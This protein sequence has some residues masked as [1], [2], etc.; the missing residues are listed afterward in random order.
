[1]SSESVVSKQKA[2][3]QSRQQPDASPT[4]PIARRTRASTEREKEQKRREK[5]AK[6]V[7]EQND[8]LEKAREKEREKAYIFSKEQEKLAAMEKQIALIEE[9]VAERK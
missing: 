3:P 4:K 5:D 1:M 8:K 9:F 6:R 7:E 2:D